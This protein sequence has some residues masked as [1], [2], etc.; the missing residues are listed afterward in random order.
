M[1]THATVSITVCICVWMMS[2]NL[3]GLECHFKSPHVTYT[4]RE[5]RA[6]GDLMQNARDTRA[7]SAGSAEWLLQNGVLLLASGQ[8]RTY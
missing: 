2:A 6:L 7:P 4:H 8:H 1:E 3:F 5:A